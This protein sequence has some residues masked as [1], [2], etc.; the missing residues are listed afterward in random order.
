MHRLPGLPWPLDALE[1]Q[2]SAKTLLLHH[3][4]HHAAYVAKLNE[5]VKGTDLAEMSLEE[6]ILQS[7]GAVFNNAAQHWNHSFF[8]LCLRP[9]GSSGPGAAL[10]AAIAA[11]FGSL[12]EL[13]KKFTETAAGTFGSGWTWLVADRR[14]GLEILSTS[15]ADNPLRDGKIPL[16]ACDVWEHAY[17]LD[18]QNRRPDYLTVFWALAD[19][20]RASQRYAAAGRRTR[21]P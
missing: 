7:E 19:W 3:G 6:I 9:A 1:P 5:L 15:N 8:W 18:Y 4:K 17:Y 14:G 2:M 16:L 20:D 13:K 12:A 10:K 11:S 21:Q